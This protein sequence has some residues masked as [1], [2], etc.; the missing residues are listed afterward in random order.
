M[1]NYKTCRDCG[2][3]LL[4]DDIAIF[5][6]LVDRNAD[7]FLCIDC[8]AKGLGCTREDIEGLIEYFRSTGKCSLFS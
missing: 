8:L 2:A 6:K 3:E 4:A 7:T 1:S 5:R